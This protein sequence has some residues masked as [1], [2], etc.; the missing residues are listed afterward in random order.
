MENK[1]IKLSDELSSFFK[2]FY[3]CKKELRQV[4]EKQNLLI[5]HLLK[6]VVVLFFF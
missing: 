2:A 5:T 6:D 1:V 3:R 4:K